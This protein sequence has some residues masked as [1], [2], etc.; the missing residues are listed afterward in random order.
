M[1]EQVDYDAAFADFASAFAKLGKAFSQ[2]IEAAMP[3]L[4]ALW[5]SL[6]E[7]YRGAGSPYG[8]T[9]DGLHRWLR[10]Q[11]ELAAAEREAEYQRERTQMA[12]DMRARLGIGLQPA[13]EE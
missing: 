9:E 12:L 3:A 7:Q 8:D 5:E 6:R 11:G 1:S 2:I 4:T 13:G 10:E